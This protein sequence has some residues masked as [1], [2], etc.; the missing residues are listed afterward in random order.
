MLE[1]V[2]EPDAPEAQPDEI[3]FTLTWAP[4]GDALTGELKARNVGDRRVRLSGKPA[5]TPLDVDGQP[6][7]TESIITLEMKL[8][9][10]V[11]LDPGESATARVGWAG[12][13]GADAGGVVRVEWP[14]GQAD[15]PAEGP[16]QPA[17]SGPATNLFSSWFTRADS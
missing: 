3:A 10:Y 16:R 15:V 9:G 13:D 17:A 6:L 8:P 14:G 1:V 5:L 12:W 7:E 2:T 11:D 4:D